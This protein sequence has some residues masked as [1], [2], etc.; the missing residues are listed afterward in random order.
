MESNALARLK[1]VAGR[2][3]T[4][5][6]HYGRKTNQ[7]RH[8]ARDDSRSDDKEYRGAKNGEYSPHSIRSGDHAPRFVRC[9]SMRH[10]PPVMGIQNSFFSGVP[11]A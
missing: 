1:R 2:Q 5:L 6:T 11:L 7:P 9:Q 10:R 4:R 8:V 3:T